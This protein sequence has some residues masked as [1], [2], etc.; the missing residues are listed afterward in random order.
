MKLKITQSQLQNITK[1]G[2]FVCVIALIVQLFP[3]QN[4]F[5]YQFEVGKPWSYELMTA[6]FDFP[7]YKSESQI[8]KEQEEFLKD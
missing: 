2:L 3:S 7:I 8:A 1:L 5:K 6:A 4:K